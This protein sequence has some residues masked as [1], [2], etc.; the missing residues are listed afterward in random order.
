MT[1]V[2]KRIKLIILADKYG[3]D[4]V[5]E[6]KRDAIASNSEDKKHIKKCI[7]RTDTS[8]EKRPILSK[9]KTD[10]VF[11]NGYALRSKNAITPAINNRFIMCH[12]RSDPLNTFTDPCHSCGRHG[13]ATTGGHALFGTLPLVDDNLYQLPP[14]TSVPCFPHHLS[15]HQLYNNQ[16]CVEKEEI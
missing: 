11:R 3:W 8:H 4:F 9:R 12:Y 13:N 16:Y 15:E 1:L 14:P 2:E 6:Y 5:K 10:G 7:K